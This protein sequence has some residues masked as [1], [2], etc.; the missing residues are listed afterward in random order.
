[1]RLGRGHRQGT[2]PRRFTAKFLSKD[3]FSGRGRFLRTAR[4]SFGEHKRTLFL[5]VA[6]G[7]EVRVLPGT[8]AHLSPD[9]KTFV[10][11]GKIGFHFGDTATGKEIGR[12]D[13][14]MDD[15]IRTTIAFAPDG[16]A[17]AVVDREKEVWVCAVPG[18]KVLAAFPLPASIGR[19][20]PIDWDTA[21]GSPR[22][23]KPCGWRP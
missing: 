22:M 12:L 1:M 3:A 20:K 18:G 16:R 2:T 11:R 19:S 21:W 5:E 13:V 15:S 23:A 7:K 4:S 17:L 10:Y 14:A 9:T 8:V 6:T